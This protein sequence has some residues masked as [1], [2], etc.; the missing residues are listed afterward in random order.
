MAYSAE[1]D[2]FK[3][4]WEGKKYTGTGNGGSC[5][6]SPSDGKFIQIIEAVD[7]GGNVHEFYYGTK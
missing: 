4:E 2:G 3:F 1:W 6:K 5:L 7:E